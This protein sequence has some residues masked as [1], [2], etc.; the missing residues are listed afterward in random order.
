[1]A[2]FCEELGDGDPTAWRERAKQRAE[3]MKKLMTAKDG[4]MYDYNFE[5]GKLSPVLSAAS[6]FP[7]F[8]GILT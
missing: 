8:G 5:S 3:L 7:L 4:C 1:M 6:F 2:Y